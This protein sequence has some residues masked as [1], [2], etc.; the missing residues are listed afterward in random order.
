MKKQKIIYY[1]DE[2]NDE[3]SGAEIKPRKIDENYKYI[4]KN[5]IWNITAFFYKTY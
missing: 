5:I 4:H 3:F 1:N 2:L